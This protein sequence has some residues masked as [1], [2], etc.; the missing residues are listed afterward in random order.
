M[1]ARMD[2]QEI[3][4]QNLR[5]LVKEQFNGRIASLA[6]AVDRAP[7]YLSRCLTDNVHHQKGIGE[8]FARDVE[9]KVFLPAYWLDL[10]RDP[11]AP[12]FPDSKLDKT[13]SIRDLE[14][15][16]V[17]TWD[18]RTPLDSD[19]VAVPFL[20]EVE[21]SAG[22]GRFL[23]EE[24]SDSTLRFSKKDLRD[25]GVPF[26][27]ARCVTVRGNSMLPIL[28]DGATVGVNIAKRSIG[29]VVDGE[30]Y[31]ISHNGQ[32]RIK[33]VYRLPTGIRLR[34]FNRE[35]HPDEDYPFSELEHEDMR[36]LGH[37]FWWAMYAR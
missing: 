4:R 32:L 21:L 37:V 15:S 1:I 7:S 18:E 17:R 30:L 24:S 22:S 19:E 12:A 16:P 34:S 14:L 10:E 25:N 6:A 23:V 13:V 29:D 26:D 11:A 20:R 36:L 33:Q 5:T 27:K 28:R 31:A 9:K 3:R 2:I 35:E 8:R